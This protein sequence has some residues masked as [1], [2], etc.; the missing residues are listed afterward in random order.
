MSPDHR[1]PDSPPV[2]RN[3]PIRVWLPALIFT[4]ALVLFLIAAFFLKSNM[5]PDQRTIALL[6]FA[7]LAGFSTAFL[8]GTV[9]LEITGNT[10]QGR[11][12]G[13]SATAGVAVFVLCYLYPPYFFN[14]NPEKQSNEGLGQSFNLTLTGYAGA[15]NLVCALTTIP[16]Y[17]CQEFSLD[18]EM[19]Y[20]AKVSTSNNN[21]TIHMMDIDVRCVLE[22]SIGL[23]R[24]MNGFYNCWWH[25]NN[26][27]HTNNLPWTGFS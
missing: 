4:S 2:I 16:D 14:H 11:K 7:L 22:D 10:S 1:G 17:S 27:V 9:L 5:T 8:G 24:K 25:K 15:W 3:T 19:A 23:D 26:N 18:G 12:F 20:T 21:V 6:L 13:L